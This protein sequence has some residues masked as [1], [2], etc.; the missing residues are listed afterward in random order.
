[1]QVIRSY[2]Q[3]THDHQECEEDRQYLHDLYEL[4]D[5]QLSVA[6]DEV[7]MMV[8]VCVVRLWPVWWQAAV[9]HCVNTPVPPRPIPLLNVIS[10]LLSRFYEPDSNTVVS[11]HGIAF[12]STASLWGESTI[13]QWVPLTKGQ[14]MGVG[15]FFVVSL[16]EM[17]NEQSSWWRVETP[18]RRFIVMRTEKNQCF[19]SQQT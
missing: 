6:W 12:R 11:L 8:P 10:C 7:I 19:P 17:L 18:R 16:N 4:H 13:H 15:V 3:A 1:M 5:E 9:T 2:L 14:V